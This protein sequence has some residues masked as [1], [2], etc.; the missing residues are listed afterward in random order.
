VI[1]WQLCGN[2]FVKVETGKEP[3]A[4][5]SIFGLTVSGG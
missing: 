4:V 2:Q 5:L 1:D 3:G